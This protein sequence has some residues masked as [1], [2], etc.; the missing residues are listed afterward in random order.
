MFL[1][2]ELSK[3]VIVLHL[4][5]FDYKTCVQILGLLPL[6]ENLGIVCCYLWTN[7]SN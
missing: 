6:G 7:C 4:V 5:Y 1:F 2:S 3:V